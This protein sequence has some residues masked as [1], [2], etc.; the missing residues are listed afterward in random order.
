MEGSCTRSLSSG[1]PNVNLSLRSL[2][3]YCISQLFAEDDNY[4]AVIAKFQRSHAAYPPPAPRLS[5][6]SAVSTL[7]LSPTLTDDL[8][9][10][11]ISP[12]LANSDTQS[13][14]PTLINELGTTS[15]YTQGSRKARTPAVLLL[16]PRAVEIQNL[17]VLSFL[18]LEK[19][20]RTKESSSTAITN[21]Y[22]YPRAC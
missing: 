17:V 10:A 8:D 14:A 3:R 5:S 9:A 13:I 21:G 6:P 15:P 12:T 22:M 18:F 1:E 7:S 2:M 4:T 11:S 16:T 19:Y 20:H